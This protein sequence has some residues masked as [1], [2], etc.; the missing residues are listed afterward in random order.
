MS[1]SREPCEQFMVPYRRFYSPAWPSR[2]VT[3]GLIRGTRR[4]RCRRSSSGP[5]SR[6]TGL[7]RSRI[8]AT[9][10]NR[11]R[12]SARRAA[13]PASDPAKARAADLQAAAGQAGKLR[14]PRRPQMRAWWPGWPARARRVREPQRRRAIL[15]GGAG[16]EGAHGRRYEM[17]AQRRRREHRPRTGE[18][19]ARE[20]AG[21]DRSGAD[22]PAQQPGPAGELRRGG[23]RRSGPGA[24]QPLARADLL[25]RA[26][27]PRRRGRDRARR[28]LRCAGPADH[29]A[30]DAGERKPP[31]G[32]ARTGP[33][34]RRCVSRS[35]RA[36]RGSR[37][38]PRRKAPG[39]WRR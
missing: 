37:P 7:M 5:H 32:D 6:A 24:G 31:A 36:R 1:K 10:A 11:T 21:A 17:D 33:R 16:G 20:T 25:V 8:C 4:R 19:A 35:I 15:D 9:G 12:R 3:A 2:R 23:N 29:P 22:R 34:A 14:R 13:M 28:F 38:S 30:L 39:T 26:A 27:A 18:G